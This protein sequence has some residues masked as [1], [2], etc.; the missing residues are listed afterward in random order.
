MAVVQIGELDLKS[1][2]LVQEQSRNNN[3]ELCAQSAFPLL[4]ELQTL[5]DDDFPRR[6]SFAKNIWKKLCNLTNRSSTSYESLK[7]SSKLS[8]KKL[9]I[10]LLILFSFVIGFYFE[11]LSSLG[12]PILKDLPIISLGFN[13]DIKSETRTSNWM[14]RMPDDV[15]LSQITIPGTHNSASFIL[16]NRIG[17]GKYATRD[18]RYCQTRSIQQQLQDG[19]RFFDFHGYAIGNSR[20]MFNYQGRSTPSFNYYFDQAMDD[21]E[22]FLLQNPKETI[23]IVPKC[24][25]DTALF[26]ST[27]NRAYGI[28]GVFTRSDGSKK[29]YPWYKGLKEFPTLGDVRGK[30]VLFSTESPPLEVPGPGA[31]IKVWKDNTH[32]AGVY[33]F[34]IQDWYRVK[35]DAA[36]KS[37]TI[38]N[39]IDN[40]L[41]DTVNEYWLNFLSCFPNLLGAD[42]FPEDIAGKINHGHMQTLIRR[43]FGRL[44]YLVMDFYE[45]GEA[46]G[47]NIIAQISSN[48]RISG[49]V[50]G[51]YSLMNEARGDKV[52]DAN[53]KITDRIYISGSD[54]DCTTWK[55]VRRDNDGWFS[56]YNRKHEGFL[57]AGSTTIYIRQ[58]YDNDVRDSARWRLVPIPNSIYFLLQNR[59]RYQNG[60]QNQYLDANGDKSGDYPY[61]THYSD[62]PYTHW[63]FRRT[64]WD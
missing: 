49:T 53:S 15:Y 8:S 61:M 14:S 59:A 43:P 52:L 23:I 50:V 40:A 37:R 32:D 27:W 33:P 60:D 24:D 4:N 58:S 1:S 47:N 7:S 19:I 38:D 25:T 62:G 39:T 20:I 41:K 26:Q 54:N 30:L 51:W 55:I 3:D 2:L 44:G 17:E 6:N 22:N 34:Q 48:T 29:V 57:D 16:P 9:L 42:G 31:V 13:N 35:S 45:R 63:R 18:A 36:D 11:A 28:N 64:I 5:A 10:L 21:M 56:L 46:V 12:L